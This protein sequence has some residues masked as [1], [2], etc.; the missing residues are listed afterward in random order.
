MLKIRSL[1]KGA[2]D[3]LMNSGPHSRVF[4]SKRMYIRIRAWKLLRFFLSIHFQY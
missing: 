2:F 3:R 4:L 1:G